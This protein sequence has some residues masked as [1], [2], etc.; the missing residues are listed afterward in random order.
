MQRLLDIYDKSHKVLEPIEK[1]RKS[2]YNNILNSIWLLVIFYAFLYNYLDAKLSF[3]AMLIGCLFLSP[4]TWIL[5]KKNYPIASRLLFVASGNFY[6]YITG[7]GFSNEISVEYYY[8]PAIMIPLLIFKDSEKKSIWGSILF[9]LFL[10]VLSITIGHG[11]VPQNWLTLDA[12]LSLIKKINFIGA[13]GLSFVLLQIFMKTTFRLKDLLVQHVELEA[14]ILKS[15]S[16]ELEE[17]QS[18]SKI[19][20]WKFNCKDSALTWSAEHY[21]IFEIDELKP[22]EE[23]YELY[24]GRLFKDDLAPLNTYMQ[25]AQQNGTEFVFDHRDFLKILIE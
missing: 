11:F 5:E 19:G 7:L 6:I 15:L 23:L 22:S 16:A 4:L 20:S 9:S 17:A 24:K 14:S 1:S 12:P 3:F 10:W 25:E 8:L 18:I 13:F 2:L 21:R